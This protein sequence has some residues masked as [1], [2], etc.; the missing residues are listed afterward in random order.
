MVGG[1]TSVEVARKMR[2]EAHGLDLHSGF[3]ILKERIFDVVGKPL[4]WCCRIRH[5]TTW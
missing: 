5:I 3:D 2:I 1:A 4:T